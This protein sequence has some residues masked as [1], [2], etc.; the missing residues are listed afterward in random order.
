MVTRQTS[1][2]AEEMEVQL[3]KADDQLDEQRVDLTA[4]KDES[5]KL[6]SQLD[7]LKIEIIADVTNFIR[8]LISQWNQDVKAVIK[9]IIMRNKLKNIL[10]FGIF[11]KRLSLSQIILFFRSLGYNIINIVDPSCFVLKT[12][13]T[14]PTDQDTQDLDPEQGM[15]FEPKLPPPLTWNKQLDVL[16]PLLTTRSSR[17]GGTKRKRSYSRKRRT[18]K[19]RCVTRRYRRSRRRN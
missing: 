5:A 4:A 11:H 8:A 14:F 2:I 13:R 9:N 19:K 15:T 16:T 10:K 18:R 7:K 17:A 12:P 3:A 6:E 1:K